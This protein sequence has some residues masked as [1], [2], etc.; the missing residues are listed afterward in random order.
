MRN[1]G[2]LDASK[3]FGMLLAVCVCTAAP[4][5]AD[6]FDMFAHAGIG[7]HV[8]AQGLS[9]SMAMLWSAHTSVGDKPR[10][11]ELPLSLSCDLGCLALEGT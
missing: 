8:G 10:L 3:A 5:Q 6:T 7:L 9:M 2:G 11:L 1:A 4:C